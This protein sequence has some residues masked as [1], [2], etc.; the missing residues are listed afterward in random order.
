MGAFHE[1]HLELMRT[2][3]QECAFAVVSLFVNPTQFGPHEDFDKYPRNE[4]RDFA[5]ATEAGVDVMFAP[6]SAEMYPKVGTMVHVQGVSARWEGA[7]RA[8]HFDGVA[9]VV[10]KLFNIVRPTHAYFGLKDYQQCAVIGQMVRDLNFA[11]ELRLLDTV[12]ENDGLAMSSRNAYLDAD[13][14]RTAAELYATLNQ[15]SDQLR[16]GL[17][18]DQVLRSGSNRLSALGFEVHYYALVDDVTL[19]PS[20]EAKAGSRIVAAAKLGQ[21]RLIDNISVF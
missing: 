6:D 8:G 10:A 15:S 16:R 17:P 21:T 1:G 9:T 11:L 18:A 14:R 3:K 13:E 20:D 7:Y 2:A 19:E 12:R 5:M 4:E